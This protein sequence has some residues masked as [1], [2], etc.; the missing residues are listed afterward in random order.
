MV[1]LLGHF[2]GT[3]A[4]SPENA[5]EP[6]LGSRS[7][8]CGAKKMGQKFVKK[9]GLSVLWGAKKWVYRFPAHFF[10]THFFC[11]GGDIPPHFF[12]SVRLPDEHVPFRKRLQC[13]G[14]GWS[15]S[16]AAPQTD[17]TNGSNAV[18]RI[19]AVRWGILDSPKN[20]QKMSWG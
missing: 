18:M 13:S 12:C 16:C 3:C 10:A 5:R 14:S 20:V 9:M 1:T 8:L 11:L 4:E 2:S 6:I 17:P 7:F 15:R 19:L